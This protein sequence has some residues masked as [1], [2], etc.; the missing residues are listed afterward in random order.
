MKENY[1]NKKL[2]WNYQAARCNGRFT[3]MP[4][5]KRKCHIRTEYCLNNN[6]SPKV[7]KDMMHLSN[8]H[9]RNLF[10]TGK[11][12]PND[13]ILLNKAFPDFLCNSEA[14]SLCK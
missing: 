5:F 13:D 8:H 2:S 6:L 9:I 11:Y 7:Y 3:K 12:E 1:K 14:F 4:H 10:V